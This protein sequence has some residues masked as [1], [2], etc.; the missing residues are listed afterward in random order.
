MERTGMQDTRST[1]ERNEM[2]EAVNRALGSVYDPCSLQTAIP[3]SIVDMGLV[4][5]VDVTSEGDVYVELTVTSP[6]CTLFPSFARAAAETVQA[7]PGVK[8]VDVKVETSNLWTPRDIVP[9][10]RRRIE[11]RHRA[12]Q[13]RA[14]V[15]PRQWQNRR[16]S[17]R[18]QPA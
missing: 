9:E 1:A 10:V 12:G 8:S 5:A 17:D 18:D 3:L 11:E 7:V 15:R 4:R 6:G 13:T 2:I 14:N 16:L